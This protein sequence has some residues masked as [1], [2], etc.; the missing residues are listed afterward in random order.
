MNKIKVSLTVLLIVG[1]FLS[2]S[3]AFAQNYT[4]T[5]QN[6]LP[7]FAQIAQVLNSIGAQLDVL[8]KEVNSLQG[9]I[10]TQQTVTPPP[11]INY[12]PIVPPPLPPTPLPTVTVSLDPVTPASGSFAPG[13]LN[14]PFTRV[15][16]VATGGNASLNAIQIVSNSSNALTSLANIRVYDLITGSLIGSSNWQGFNGVFYYAWIY[17]TTP[18]TL[19]NYIIRTLA[20]VAD[21][22]TTAPTPGSVR[23]GVGGLNFAFPGASISGLPIFGNSMSIFAAG[24]PNPPSNLVATATSSPLQVG[25]VWQDNSTNE[26]GFQ[27]EKAT[28]SGN[29]LVTA[30]TPPVVATS[31]GTFFDSNVLPGTFY[32]Y[33]VAAFGLNGTSTY[34]NIASVT[35][36][37]TAGTSTPPSNLIGFPVLPNLVFLVWQD[38]SN[39]ELGF[40][41]QR[42]QVSP[43]SGFV[44]VATTAV[45]V[46]YYVNTPVLGNT[47]YWYRIRA[48]NGFGNSL[49]SNVISLTTP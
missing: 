27:V 2:V 26:L 36:P 49:F 35:T 45:N 16:L 3:G 48:F 6:Q 44:S 7:F 38:N 14:V 39:N 13:T 9:K 8:Q 40:E 34:S 22:Q 43:V 4:T 5:P 25:L 11:T 29:F 47:T 24:T 32:Q 28:T 23:L 20:V 10:T 30:L 21:I 31:S 12:F 33:R 46:F 17:P 42:S 15:I 19:N 41:V 37:G 18:I 1:G